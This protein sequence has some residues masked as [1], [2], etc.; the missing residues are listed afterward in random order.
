MSRFDADYYRRFYRRGGVHDRRQIDHLASAVHGMC[1]WWGVR[2]RTVLDIG[3]G[4]GR[5]RDWYRT[6]HPSV[7]VRSVDISEYACRRWGH[8]LRDISTW[9]PPRPADLVVCH[10]VLQY[11]TDRAATQAIEHLA[12]GTR[13][14]MYLE[15]PT[16]DDLS[17]V[18]DAEVSDVDDLHGRSATWYRK[19]LAPHFRQAG[20]GLWVRRD[21]VHLFDLEGA[22]NSR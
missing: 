2:P 14:V 20:A 11:L 3:A 4:V 6:N 18:V 13:Y 15:A 8:E 1:C 16:A 17:H 10:S 12:A 22:P 21:T 5:W 9:R 19:R 7:R